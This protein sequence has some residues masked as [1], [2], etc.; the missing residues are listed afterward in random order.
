[1]SAAV[2]QIVTIYQ[3]VPKCGGT[4]FR[5]ACQAYFTETHEEVPSKDDP[6]KWD[7]FIRNKVNFSNLGPRP[8]ISGH[9]IHDGVRPRERY[10]DEIALGNVRIVTVLREPLARLISGH[11]FAK[12]NGKKLGVTFEQRLK[13]AKNPMSR[14]LGFAGGHATSFLKTFFLV[15][16]TEHLQMTCDLLAHL[17]QREPV[18]VP[19]VNVTKDRAKPEIAPEVIEIFRANNIRDYELYEAAVDLFRERCL[20]ELGREP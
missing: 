16:L 5:E 7:A 19:R 11:A 20:T 15:G 1:M 13:R 4:S 9:F 3:H 10:A 12:Q 2:P 14:Y 6:E 18:E 17:I 8:L